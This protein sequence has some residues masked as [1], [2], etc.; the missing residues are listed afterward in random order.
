MSKSLPLS[1]T[2]PE[3]ASQAFGWD[4]SVVR[5]GS[6]ARKTWKCPEGHAFVAEIWKR[7]REYNS[8]WQVIDLR[9]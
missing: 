6:T 7:K 9:K 2:H 8:V 4:P 3:L 1:E 5:D